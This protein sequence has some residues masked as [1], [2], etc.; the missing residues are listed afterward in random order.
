MK[1]HERTQR[2]RFWKFV[3]LSVAIVVVAL[4]IEAGILN[5]INKRN[6]RRT[7]QMMLDQL[8]SVLEKNEKSENDLIAS[9]KE[10][11]IVR[12]KAVA[13][14]LEAKPEAESSVQELQKIARLMSVD[15]IHLFD[16]SGTIYSGTV[17]KYY[18]YSMTSG[19]QM[20]FFQPMLADKTLSM[21][22]DVTPNTSEGK[23]M[24]YAMVW[25]DAGSH[26]IE[27][28][29]KPVR[30]LEE[31]KQNE[32]DAVI[33]NM[34]MYE[35]I[36]MYVAAAK[37]GKILGATETERIGKTLK[38]IGIADEDI[39]EQGRIV[40][41]EDQKYRA[42]F[43]QYGDY[44]IG[45]T[46]GLFVNHASD[47]YAMLSV[48]IFLTIGAVCS[49]F[50]ISRV[51]KAH[52]ERDEQLAALNSMS[53]VYYSL[54][55]IDLEKM[56][57]IAYSAK[58]EVAEIGDRKDLKADEKMQKV[59]ALTV[60]D[61]YQDQVQAFTDL[62]TLAERMKGKKI[63]TGEFIGIHLGWFRASFI[64]IEYDKEQRPV[65]V[66]FTTRS[67]DEEKKREENLIY[68]SNTDELTGCW[69]R[70]AYEQAIPQL[71]GNEHFVYIS[72]DVNGL[73]DVND[74]LGHAAGDELI[75]GAASCMKQSF[76]TFGSIYRIGGD[77]FVAIVFTEEE[78]MKSL[79]AAFEQRVSA[80][81]GQLVSSMA[82]SSGY[83]YG[84]EKK[85]ETPYDI[86]K[87]ADARMYEDKA[88]YYR[89]KGIDR[90]GIHVK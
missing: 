6:M 37:S 52:K 7:S 39:S 49:V 24:M 90:R 79:R 23:P 72:M 36:D 29:I 18:G 56:S 48:G 42:F 50:M 33:S 16:E 5:N 10:D 34:P 31:L 70:R 86:A 80:W 71:P 4:I 69:N 32:I 62:N 63:I 66:I 8:T 28:G 30:L 51:F 15:E 12:A 78:K 87:T 54:H 76:G 83:V 3:L 22:Q 67:I 35:G 26:M 44:T 17:P 1:K 59:M 13:Y 43:R 46:Y 25:D 73:K 2:K 20:A 61:I 64:G 19:D 45:V 41:I 65:K 38:K 27:V 88:A 40:T 11:Y 57:L 55:L 53:E 85:W 84:T 68:R 47:L 9:M 89:K 77:E 60:V 82:I 14:I 75:R 81:S 21:C 74:T 58:N